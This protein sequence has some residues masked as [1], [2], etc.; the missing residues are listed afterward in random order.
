MPGLQLL[1]F[2]ITLLNAKKHTPKELT[3]L[4]FVATGVYL[5]KKK[6]NLCFASIKTNF[7]YFLMR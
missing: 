2:S 1:L 3:L 6:T 4:R 5:Y 7:S